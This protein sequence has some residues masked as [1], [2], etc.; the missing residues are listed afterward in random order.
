MHNINHFFEAGPTRKRYLRG[1]T[2]IVIRTEYSV[3]TW[4]NTWFRGGYRMLARTCAGFSDFPVEFNSDTMDGGSPPMCWSAQ[5]DVFGQ[6]QPCTSSAQTNPT[7]VL[8]LT[9][10]PTRSLW[11]ARGWHEVGRGSPAIYTSLMIFTCT[12]EKP[13]TYNIYNVRASIRV[14]DFLV[15]CGF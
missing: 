5:N 2:H 6:F 9:L 3:Q 7:P 10:Y 8:T 15:H 11:G 1:N 12:S 4:G 14:M 13:C